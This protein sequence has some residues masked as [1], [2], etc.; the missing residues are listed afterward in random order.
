[1]WDRR[2]ETRGALALLMACDSLNLSEMFVSLARTRHLAS[3][4]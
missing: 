1:M 3:D 2:N 4:A